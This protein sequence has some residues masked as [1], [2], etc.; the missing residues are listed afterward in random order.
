MKGA[1]RDVIS[2]KVTKLT[3]ITHY[4]FYQCNII[5][6]YNPFIVSINHKSWFIN[7]DKKEINPLQGHIKPL[8]GVISRAF[9]LKIR[10]QKVVRNANIV[11]VIVHFIVR[12]RIILCRSAPDRCGS[13]STT[14]H[15]LIMC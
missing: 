15:T 5:Q 11:M 3:Y 2:E 7:I 1:L 13:I 6:K 9:M 4:A 10:Q 14:V 12:F 8:S